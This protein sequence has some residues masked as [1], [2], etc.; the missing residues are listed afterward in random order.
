MV[1]C[2]RHFC[3]EGEGLVRFVALAII[4]GVD[5]NFVGAQNPVVGIHQETYIQ[6]IDFLVLAEVQF[7]VGINTIE[8]LPVA[9]FIVVA[10]KTAV[11]KSAIATARVF[12]T[13]VACWTVQLLQ[14][15]HPHVVAEITLCAY[16]L[17]QVI[18]TSCFD[19]TRT[20]Q[21]DRIVING[22]VSLHFL[23]VKGVV[24][25]SVVENGS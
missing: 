19:K 7:K 11:K 10:A 22:I 1:D 8:T 18:E 14:S 17:A 21:D 6:R 12:R 13:V 20:L 4:G 24:D 9:V 2:Q 15:S 16:R 3:C 23:P 5:F 25:F